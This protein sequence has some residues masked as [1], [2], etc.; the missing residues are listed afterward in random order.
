V[1]VAQTGHLYS[2]QTANRIVAM[3]IVRDSTEVFATV[4]GLANR[5]GLSTGSDIS[6]AAS[7]FL[8]YLDSP[9]T[10][11]SV[12]YKTQAKLNNV[13]GTNYTAQIGDA[14]SVITLM[15]IAV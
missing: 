7:V 1:L 8:S 15:E 2:D 3:N 5:G 10:T 14:T 6:I 4:S 9:N 12:A 11:S 13:T